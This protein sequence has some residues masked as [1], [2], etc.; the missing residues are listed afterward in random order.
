MSTHDP[1]KIENQTF[2]LNIMHQVFQIYT[3]ESEILLKNVSQLLKQY[4][5]IHIHSWTARGKED[6][7]K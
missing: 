4:N 7:K 1:I 2:L 5:Y 3:I 6:E